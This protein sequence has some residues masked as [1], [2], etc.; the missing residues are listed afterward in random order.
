MIK[1]TA[2]YKVIQ[3]GHVYSNLATSF[4]YRV[5]RVDLTSIPNFRHKLSKPIDPKIIN[6]RIHHTVQTY[7]NLVSNK[8]HIE[9]HP[10][11][12]IPKD[13]CEIPNSDIRYSRVLLGWVIDDIHQN[14]HHN[15][16]EGNI[17]EDV[18]ECDYDYCYSCL[19][20]FLSFPT[21]PCGCLTGPTQVYE[22]QNK[23]D[24]DH[25]KHC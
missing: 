22:G 5:S 20:L 21:N 11:V 16:H 2:S 15:H 13:M 23:G 25:V 10:H 8:T 9:V 4:C 3:Y 1:D 14:I 19:S 7:K 6:H 17:A 12:T 24:G 18:E